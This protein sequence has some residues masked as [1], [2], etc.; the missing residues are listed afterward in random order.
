MTVHRTVSSDRGRGLPTPGTGPRGPLWHKIS[1]A[2]LF[3]ACGVGCGAP[4]EEVDDVEVVGSERGRRVWAQVAE[5]WMA[6]A[7]PG[8]VCLTRVVTDPEALPILNRRLVDRGYPSNGQYHVAERRVYLD[9]DFNYGTWVGR[10]ELCHAVDYQE[11]LGSLDAVLPD[12]GDEGA[13]HLRWYGVEFNALEVFAYWC[14]GGPDFLD[15]MAVVSA[16]AGRDDLADGA[17]AVRDLVYPE[18]PPSLFDA[19]IPVADSGVVAL[20]QAS[21]ILTYAWPYGQHSASL[22]WAGFGR[23]GSGTLD[24]PSGTF[25]E[26]WDSY[27][28]EPVTE[29]SP[30][31]LNT[32]PFGLS[33]D[34]PDGPRDPRMVAE[35]VQPLYPVPVFAAASTPMVGFA[36]GSPDGRFS[37]VEGAVVTVLGSAWV[38]TEGLW[39][40]GQDADLRLRWWRVRPEDLPAASP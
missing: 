26:D 25:V 32:H 9:T 11:Q 38:T 3:G 10:H 12:A 1:F 2:A 7:G 28:D 35:G 13:W 17:L 21:A 15:A 18:A 27:A 36:F 29:L 23:G 31:I 22:S 30:M 14:Q 37:L 6:E 5:S 39:I 40:V 4:C 34:E 19:P 24:F 8:R 33:L 20:P 16:S